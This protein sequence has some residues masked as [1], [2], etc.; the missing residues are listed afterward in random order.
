MLHRPSASHCFA[1]SHILM[2]FCLVS[3]VFFFLVS[4]FLLCSQ[5][6][7]E[8]NQGST[9]IILDVIQCRSF[10][11]RLFHTEI[12][13]GENIEFGTEIE[14]SKFGI[15]FHRFS[16]FDYYFYIALNCVRRLLLVHSSFICFDEI[17]NHKGIN[18]CKNSSIDDFLFFRLF[19]VVRKFAHSFGKCVNICVKSKSFHVIL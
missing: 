12:G 4:S 18:G 15:Y 7:D 5:Q 8:M 1:S 6:T 2:C 9:P 16:F 14:L 19:F 13:V 17:R 3:K 10:H 11:T